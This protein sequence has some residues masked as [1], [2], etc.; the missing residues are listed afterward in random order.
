MK[1]RISWLLSFALFTFLILIEG[2]SSAFAQSQFERRGYVVDAQETRGNFG[3]QAGGFNIDLV[4]LQ[5]PGVFIS[6]LVAKRG[7]SPDTT[8]I[9]L[10]ID[11]RLVT[12]STIAA[13]RNFGL[14][15]MNTS[16][17]AVVSSV[18][19]DID[20][21]TIGYPV[22]LGFQESLI[23]RANNA[24]PSTQDEGV[25]QITGVVVHGN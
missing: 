9:E 17:S 20:T 16:G 21:V 7:G 24:P 4:T 10:E 5:G 13:L 12:S 6:A 15:Q 19:S 3:A 22:P 8:R 18:P 2:N 25:L 23:L 1:K 14:T 11:G